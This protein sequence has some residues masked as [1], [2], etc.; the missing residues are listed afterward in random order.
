MAEHTEDC[1][2][3]YPRDHCKGRGCP[4]GCHADIPAH[5]PCPHEIEVERLRL[6]LEKAAGR[7][8]HLSTVLSLSNKPSN[9][10]GALEWSEEARAVLEERPS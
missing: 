6:A 1:C 4:C 10:K 9:A 3:N 2:F 7:L 5:L 8:G